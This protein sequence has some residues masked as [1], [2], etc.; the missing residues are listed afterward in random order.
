MSLDPIV[1]F[2][3]AL[4]LPFILLSLIGNMAGMRPQQ[5]FLPVR[6]LAMTIWNI[7]MFFGQLLIEALIY[8]FAGRTKA[9]GRKK[10]RIR[11]SK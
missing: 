7:T 6:L 8:F 9:L 10:V 2:L 3:M 11:L 4:F 5:A 1:G